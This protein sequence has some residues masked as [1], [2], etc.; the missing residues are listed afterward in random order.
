[1]R[2]DYNCAY[3]LL[4]DDVICEHKDAHRYTSP[5][6]TLH[7]HDGYEIILFLGGSNVSIYVETEMRR[8]VRGDLVLVDSYSF[9]GACVAQDSEY[10]R[11][12]INIAD[13][14][15]KK[16][17]NE[18]TD[19][20]YCFHHAPAGRIN[21]L[22]LNEEEITSFLSISDRLETA[23]RGTG[24]GDSILRRAYLSELLVFINRLHSSLPL[25]YQPSVMP[26][27]VSKT[28]E[29]IEKNINSDITVEK[30]AADLH[31][32]SDYLSR[33]FKELTG[34]TLKGFILAKR[35]SLAQ[36]LLREG[37]SPYDVCFNLSFNNYSS[38][39]RTF[40]KQ[41][42]ISPKRYQAS[43]LQKIR[44]LDKEEP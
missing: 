14:Y 15:I 13:E 43:Y 2:K 8:M 33:C 17:S 21:R 35:I 4:N 40:S 29:Y 39:S 6:D 22:I 18:D 30:I 3:S 5:D 24:Y 34:H 31:H 41:T 11:V 38:F 7:N 1:M 27:V 28:L 26:S 32:N 20:S 44:S 25:P 37:V 42:G 36:K 16:I 10:E 23:S 12:V 9:H 19:L